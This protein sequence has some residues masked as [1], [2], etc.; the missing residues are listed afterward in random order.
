MKIA[1]GVSSDA[2]GRTGYGLAVLPLTF[3]VEEAIVHRQTE[4]IILFALYLTLCCVVLLRWVYAATGRLLDLGWR[5]RWAVG[6]W[7]RSP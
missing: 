4:H 3:F 1:L 7:P 2:V 6:R 5:R